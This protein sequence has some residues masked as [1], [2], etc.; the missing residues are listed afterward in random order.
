MNSFQTLSYFSTSVD[1]SWLRK[2]IKFKNIGCRHLNSLDPFL[3]LSSAMLKTTD[4]ANV[5]L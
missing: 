5:L 3:L 1:I 2:D 4:I